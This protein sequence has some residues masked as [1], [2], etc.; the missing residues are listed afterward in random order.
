MAA[1]S[2]KVIPF[3]SGVGLGVTTGAAGAEDRSVAGLSFA[4]RLNKAIT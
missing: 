2:G 3:P 4:C 1:W